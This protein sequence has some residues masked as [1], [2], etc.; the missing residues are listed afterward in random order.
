[1]CQA[2]SRRVGQ[3]TSNL[4]PVLDKQ[5]QGEGRMNGLK[6]LMEDEEELSP[7]TRDWLGEGSCSPRGKAQRRGG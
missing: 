2:V 1:M 3:L 4:V 6:E 5:A 7:S